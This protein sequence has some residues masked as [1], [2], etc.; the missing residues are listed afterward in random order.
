[1]RSMQ[2][3]YQKLCKAV[4]KWAPPDQQW[5]VWDFVA[6]TKADCDHIYQWLQRLCNTTDYSN[7]S[8]EVRHAACGMLATTMADARFRAVF[9]AQVAANLEGCG[10][11]AAMSFNELFTLWR[12]CTCG[13]LDPVSRLEVCC[14]V[15]KTNTLRT[16]M[17]RH[18]GDKESVEVYYWVER[19]LA[20]KLGLL[21][22]AR[23]QHYIPERV[24]GIKLDSLATRVALLWRTALFDMLEGWPADM[25]EPAFPMAPHAA[26]DAA[27]HA[28][29]DELGADMA[30]GEYLRAVGAVQAR[31]T[32]AL[33]H[34]RMA[35]LEGICE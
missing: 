1:M 17:T 18:A 32:N 19:N 8:T 13:E 10:D 12:V 16:L 35:W 4:R 29:L 21:T 9:L 2:Q 15:A 27:L 5:H 23:E 14:A 7:R 31:R 11:R 25:W 26:A 34:A 20:S 33:F 22:F 28:Q 24:R 6:L 30:D 3:A